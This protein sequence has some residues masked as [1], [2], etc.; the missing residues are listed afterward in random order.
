[1]LLTYLMLVDSFLC[2]VIIA[3]ATY[4]A[5][6]LHRGM[7]RTFWVEFK[8][9]RTAFFLNEIGVFISIPLIMLA[10]VITIFKSTYVTGH[11]YWLYL[12]FL[13]RTAPCVF[14]ML[15]KKN[16]DCLRCFNKDPR[17]RSSI[18]QWTKEELEYS[19]YI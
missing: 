12:Y 10:N 8:E 17:I 1:M 6:N 16:E 3:W 19:K 9:H 18:Y 5:V 13:T 15:T 2:I 7:K 14:Y 11:S 4:V